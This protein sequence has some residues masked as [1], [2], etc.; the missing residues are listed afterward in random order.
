MTVETATVEDM[1]P[2]RQRL[3]Q[4]KFGRL[5]AW[6]PPQIVAS[7]GPFRPEA[8]EQFDGDLQQ[9]IKRCRERLAEYSNEQIAKILKGPREGSEDAK[10]WNDFLSNDLFLLEKRLPPWHAGGFG[11][12]DHVADFPYWAKMPGFDVGEL[13][14]LSVGISPADF[15]SST[16]SDL[17]RGN[18]RHELSVEI[19]FLV[20]RFELFLRIFNPHMRNVSIAPKTFIAWVDRFEEDVHPAFIGQ[21]RKFHLDRETPANTPVVAKVDKREIDTIAQLFTAMAIDYLGYKPRQSRSPIP[22]E[23]AGLA[24][25]MGMQVTDD[26]VRKYLRLGEKFIPDEWQ[27]PKH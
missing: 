24:A 3:L 6:S 12:P 8:F 11:H 15:P 20:K 9:L 21:L 1:D 4:A 7:L 14:C 2:E 13:T 18:K 27:P 10:Q 23:I 22:K 25:S 26:T 16:L 17:S 5:L 19:E